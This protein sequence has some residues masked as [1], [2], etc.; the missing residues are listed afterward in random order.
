MRPPN[1]S[2]KLVKQLHTDPLFPFSS[3]TR[4]SFCVASRFS[5]SF[6][7][8]R[9]TFWLVFSTSRLRL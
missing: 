7:E 2:T 6:W 5:P 4:F 9:V 3:L 8:V 1:E